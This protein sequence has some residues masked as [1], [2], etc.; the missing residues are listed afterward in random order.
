[1]EEI[2]F[3]TWDVKKP[4]VNHRM[5]NYQLFQRF[6][7]FFPYESHAFCRVGPH[8]RQSGELVRENGHPGKD[9]EGHHKTALHRNRC[10]IAKAHLPKALMG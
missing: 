8:L 9:G 1:M 2:Q 5:T 6:L 3:T 10:D 4:M 7:P